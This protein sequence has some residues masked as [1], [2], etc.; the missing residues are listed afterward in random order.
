MDQIP[1]VRRNWRRRIATS[2]VPDENTVAERTAKAVMDTNTV[3]MWVPAVHVHLQCRVWDVRNKS[4]SHL[5][6]YIC[7]QRWAE[8][9]GVSGCR[10]QVSEVRLTS[11]QKHWNNMGKLIILEAVSAKTTTYTRADFFNQMGKIIRH[12]A[13]KKVGYSFLFCVGVFAFIL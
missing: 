8:G 5:C 1:P 12:L 2:A 6:A 9:V 10:L 4:V 7:G 13:V 3:N 11:L